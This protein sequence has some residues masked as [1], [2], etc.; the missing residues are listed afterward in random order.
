MF[1]SH[2]ATYV[3]PLVLLLS[4]LTRYMLFFSYLCIAHF[5]ALI[6]FGYVVTLFRNE[7]TMFSYIVTRLPM[8]VSQLA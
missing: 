2:L 8:C 5:Y 4:H 1:V 7:Y 6:T 3:T